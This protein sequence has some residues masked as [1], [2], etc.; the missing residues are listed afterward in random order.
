MIAAMVRVRSPAKYVKELVQVGLWDV[1]PG[2]YNVHDFLEYNPSHAELIEKRRVAN[3]R[4]E[5]RADASLMGRIRARDNSACRYCGRQVNWKDRRGELGGTY[6]HV[7]PMSKGGP[8][9]YGNVVVA[10]RSCNSKKCNKMPEEAGMVLLEIGNL[11]VSLPVIIQSPL[12]VPSGSPSSPLPAP[13]HGHPTHGEKMRPDSALNLVWAIK[14]AVER[15]QPKAGM[16]A[17][18]TFAQENA[19]RLLVGLGDLQKAMSG[20]E[21]KI[22]LFASD[23]EMQPWTVKLFCDRYNGIGLPKRRKPGEMGEVK[24]R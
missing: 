16:W 17:P 4:S 1:E 19:S 12:P 15:E 11:P 2:G 10:C 8:S 6:D 13:D 21:R 23:P 24:W 9:T 20:L 18:D 5:M 7:I 14:A 22:A 3:E